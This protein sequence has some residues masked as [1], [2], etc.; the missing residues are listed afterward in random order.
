[1]TRATR[2]PLDKVP[3]LALALDAD[4]G[5]LLRLVNSD[6][7]EICLLRRGLG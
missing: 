2:V 3:A 7:D 6:S 4:P 1:L 5:E